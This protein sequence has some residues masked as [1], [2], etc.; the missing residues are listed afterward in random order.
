MKTDLS[1]QQRHHPGGA[2][3]PRGHAA[4]SS[5][6]SRAILPACTPSA[7]RWRATSRRPGSRWRPCRRRAVARSSLPAAARRATTR[8]SS[9]PCRGEPGKNAH[10]HQQGGAP[11]R[12]RPSARHLGE[13]GLSPSSRLPVDHEGSLDL[14]EYEKSLTPDT[15]IVSIMWA[16]NETGVIFPV[17]EAAALAKERG[18]LFHTDAVQAVGK[19][20]IDMRR[21]ADRHAVPVRP[22]A[23]CAKGHRRPLRPQGARSSRPSSSAAT[24]RKG[25]R[26]RH[27]EQPY[28][29]GLGKACELAGPQHG[30]GEHPGRPAARQAGTRLLELHPERPGQRRPRTGCRTRPTS[31]SS[32]SRA[33]PSC[34]HRRARHL[35][36][37]GLGLHLGVA[38]AFP[39]AAGHGR[40]LHHGPRSMRF[41]L[42]IYNTE[43]EI[44][45]VIEKLP[46]IIARLRELSPYWAEGSVCASVG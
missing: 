6:T 41:S 28:I 29:V 2:G 25:R 12:A 17:E 37:L 16:N 15:A 36:L 11:G 27:R 40:P 9:R 38:G 14:D 19:I 42:S 22:Q 5:G 43:E 46:P 20:P 30:R 13:A 8:P 21:N 35:R 23:P 31:A 26:G 3:S 39:R 7:A 45:F 32:S 1:R 18:I 24:R 33:R 44:D 4:L 10:H 34:S